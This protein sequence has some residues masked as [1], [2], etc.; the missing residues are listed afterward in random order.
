MPSKPN[1]GG[2][3]NYDPDNG[4]YVGNGSAGSGLPEYH[5]GSGIS[6]ADV[7]KMIL[8]GNFGQD[9]LDAYNAGT[10]EDRDQMIEY[11]HSVYDDFNT[12]NESGKRF[13]PMDPNEYFQFKNSALPS[14]GLTREDIG[15]VNR[16]TGTGKTSFYLNTALRFGY[17]E[18]LRQHIQNEGIDPNDT[19]GDW[20]SRAEFEKWEKAMDRI[21]HSSKAPRDMRADRYVG[22]GPLVAWLKGTDVLKGMQTENNGYHDHLVKG[23]YTIQELAD[24]LKALKGAVM[25]VDGSFLSFSA[26][27]DKSHMKKK[28]GS[29]TKDIL[30]KADIP[31]GQSMLV[32]SNS[33]ESEVMFPR[34]IQF[35]VKDVGTETDNLG[36]ERVVLYYGVRR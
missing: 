21:T 34:D 23:S 22:T 27:P 33:H 19:P 32:T 12:K 36:K 9:F 26:S 4:K 7:A 24:R 35:Y 17:D 18:M 28:G 16:Y 2:T 3:Q 10:Q 15:Y 5:S 6:G 1:N 20:L 25:P 31:E 8:G 11:V 13:D 29:A 14:S 30:I